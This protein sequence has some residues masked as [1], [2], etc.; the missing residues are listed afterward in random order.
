[1]QDVMY[2]SIA[3]AGKDHVVTCDDRGDSLLTRGTGSFR[4]DEGSFHAG[5]IQRSGRSLDA[6]KTKVLAL[7]GGRVVK[8]SSAS[9]GRRAGHGHCDSKQNARSRSFGR[10]PRGGNYCSPRRRRLRMASMSTLVYLTVIARFNRLAA[11]PMS[12]V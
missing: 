6:R 5:C 3:T 9:V 11:G 10:S 4:S 1:L 12:M 2:G 8:E 7:P